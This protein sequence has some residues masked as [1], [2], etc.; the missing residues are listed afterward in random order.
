MVLLGS[1][2]AGKS[3]TINIL[4][5]FLDPRW[6]KLSHKWY[7]SLLL[8]NLKHVRVLAIYPRMLSYILT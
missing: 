2:G 7:A 6:E 5:G 3:T 8:K 4:L 1:N